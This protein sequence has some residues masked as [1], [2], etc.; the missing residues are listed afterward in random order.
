MFYT[1]CYSLY[2]NSLSLSTVNESFV[3]RLPS[4]R[5]EGIRDIV[6]R[7]ILRAKEIIRSYCYGSLHSLWRSADRF[8]IR[9]IVT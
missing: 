2:I 6:L 9:F 7:F 1:L 4:E 5:D 3:S 8:K